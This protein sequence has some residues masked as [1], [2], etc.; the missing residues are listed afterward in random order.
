[1][2]ADTAAVVRYRMS[3]DIAE[4]TLNRPR[5]LNAVIPELVH[6]LVGALRRAI[7][8][9]PAVAVLRGEGRAFC[10]GF[11]LKHER[12]ERTELEHRRQIEAVQDVTRLIRRAEFP[13][14]SA[15]QGYALGNGCEF[16]LAA[17]LVVAAEGATF[18]F[19]EVEWGLSVT[20]GISQLLAQSIGSHRAK[21]LLMFG[22]HFSAEQAR[23]WGLVRCVV[24]PA[25]LDDSVR[26][27]ARELAGRPRAALVRAKRAVDLAASGP[28]EAALA[29]ETEHALLAGGSA[30]TARAITGFR[31]LADD[32][33]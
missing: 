21:D 22:E 32:G 11:D 9:G 8:D 29:I 4:I 31:A 27:M 12:G 13:V 17:D 16:A 26:A 25:D 30:E 5:S 19:P 15:V 28:L 23:G 3:E 1:M 14:I 18:G 24:P 20:G 6:Q 33:R 10:A 7:S 2:T